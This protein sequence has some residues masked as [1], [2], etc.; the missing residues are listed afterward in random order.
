[1]V[2]YIASLGIHQNVPVTICPP[3]ISVNNGPRLLA[4]S[5]LPCRSQNFR[6][7]EPTYSPTRQIFA[8]AMEL[9]C[10]SPNR[11]HPIQPPSCNNRRIY[12]APVHTQ[13]IR[14]H[15]GAATKAAQPSLLHDLLRKCLR[16]N[17]YRRIGKGTASLISLGVL[18]LTTSV[19]P[20]PLATQA[21]DRTKFVAAGRKRCRYTRPVCR[22]QT[23][24]SIGR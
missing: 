16:N 13:P 2:A 3:T 15:W 6:D 1:M 22:H 12:D 10:N 5:Q 24:T 21:P 14:A 23:L 9:R 8:H 7:V 11:T 19:Q 17:A 18:N 20:Y 4:S